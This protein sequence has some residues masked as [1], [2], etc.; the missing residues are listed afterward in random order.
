MTYK[1]YE[2]YTVKEYAALKGKSTRTI[3][4]WIEKNIIDALRK[5]EG[6]DRAHYY[7]LV[8]RNT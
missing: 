3:L 1:N 7:V 4:R 8:P 6:E 2:V 5:G